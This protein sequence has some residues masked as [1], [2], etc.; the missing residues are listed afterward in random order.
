MPGAVTEA[1]R[2]GLPWVPEDAEQKSLLSMEPTH[3]L[4]VDPGGH[5]GRFATREDQFMSS[6]GDKIK[7]VA[8]QAM[9]AVKQGV[10]NVVGSDK[11]KVQGKVQEIQGKAEV[12]LGKTKDA[13]KKGANAAADAINKRL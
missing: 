11:L 9:G 1:K 7:G 8:D 10:G 12:A 2:I 13:I 5:L 4:R 3:G 6:T